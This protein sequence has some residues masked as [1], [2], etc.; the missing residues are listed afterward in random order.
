MTYCH[1]IERNY[2]VTSGDY[3]YTVSVEFDW[4]KDT[5]ELAKVINKRPKEDQYIDY[6]VP[7]RAIRFV[8]KP[9]Q[10]D[11]HLV[12]AFRHPLE[13]PTIITPTSWLNVN[14]HVSA[15]VKTETSVLPKSK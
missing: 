7:R 11:E 13:L 10:D 4:S 2:D 9:Y 3:L 5:T 15:T 14:K 6:Q 8:E 1:I 12:N